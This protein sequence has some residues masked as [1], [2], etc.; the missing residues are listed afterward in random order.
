MRQK[1]ATESVF[2]NHFQNKPEAEA[3]K[4]HSRRRLLSALIVLLVLPALMAAYSFLI[5]PRMLSK[6]HLTIRHPDLPESWNGRKIAFFTD[7]HLGD[8][9][10]PERLRRVV[11]AVMQESPDLILFGGDLIDSRTP[12]DPSF[13]SEVI[14]I[15]S[16]LQ[17]PFGCYAVAGNH[18][19][20]LIA[21]YRYMEEMLTESGFIL[22]NNQS[23]IIDGLWLGGLSES[24]FGQPDPE[25]TFSEAGLIE[26]ADIQPGLFRLLLM[27]QPDYAAALPEETFDVAFSGHS[28]N[29]QVTFFGHPVLTVDEGKNHPYGLYDLSHN[30]ILLVSRGLGTVLIPARLGAPPEIV[31]A[32]LSRNE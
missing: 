13:S 27:H 1:L 9:Y 15:L 7:A 16:Q 2:I 8:T 24:Y 20:R 32:T 6:T 30:R 4:Q 5:E 21:E 14:E 18:D 11:Q 10:P 23:A 26:P 25:H 28:H 12:N 31:F 3:L 29:G 22:L 17:A 19:N